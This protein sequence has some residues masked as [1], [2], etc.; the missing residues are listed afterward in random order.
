METHT[1]HKPDNP[2]WY[3]LRRTLPPWRF[4][5]LL[6]E[7]VEQLPRYRVD[8]VIVMVDTEEFF[9]GHPTPEIATGYVKNLSL[10][11]AALAERGIAY[12][13]NPW[14]TR[15]HEDRGRQGA[16]TVP[17]IQT[18]VRADGTQATCL[19]C[20]LSEAWRDNLREVWAIYARTQPRVL[21]IEDDIRDFG[22]MSVSA[23][24]TS[25]DSRGRSA[26]AR[27]ENR[28]WRR[29]WRAVSRMRGGSNGWRCG[30]RR[31][32]KSCACWRR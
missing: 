5:E 18:V 6:T 23:R 11:K 24:C 15:G 17:G 13:L 12:S 26:A 29:C 30:R 25:N 32:W 9:H 22:R 19:A 28:S 16:A 8:E 10:A 1:L 4:D 31:R 20:V 3:A 21:W 27:H 14:V 7:M 2:A